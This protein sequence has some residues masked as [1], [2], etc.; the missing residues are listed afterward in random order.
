MTLLEKYKKKLSDDVD[1]LKL[2][3]KIEIS[4]RIYILES[5]KILR[6]AL[7]EQM[8]LDSC[9][10]HL[11]CCERLKDAMFPDADTDTKE[12]LRRSFYRYRCIQKPSEYKAAMLVTLCSILEKWFSS[13]QETIKI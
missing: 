3:E 5:Q 13:R 11:E 10:L 4:Y 9:I 1:C 12:W 7:S 8:N 2:E 6:D